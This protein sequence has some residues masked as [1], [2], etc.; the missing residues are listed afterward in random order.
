M[1]CAAASGSGVA[2]RALGVHVD[3]AHLHRAERVG[4]V[5]LAAVALVAEPR[6]LGAP[7][8]LVGLPHVLASEAEPERLEAHRLE[9]DV[10]GEDDEVGPRDLAA[11]LLLHRP[12]QAARLVEAR[13]VG[14][15][16]ERREALHALAATAAAVGD[17]VGAGRVP[18]HADEQRSVVCRSR[19]A[20]SP[21]TSSSPASMSAR[22]VVEVELRE[23]RRV[24]EVD[25]ERT[26][27]AARCGAAPS[28]PAG[29]ATSRGSNAGGGPSA[30][31]HRW[32]GSRSRTRCPPSLAVVWWMNQSRDEA[33]RR[34]A[35]GAA[36]PV[37]D[38][39]LV[40]LVAR[41]VGRGEARNLADRT[42]DVDG[43][44]AGAADEVVVVVADA[45]LV[46]S[47]RA[48]GLDAPDRRPPR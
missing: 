24:V 3:E 33:V 11:V 19:R 22:S 41:V 28:G 34:D 8:D 14:P 13:V 40:D 23:L 47:R 48:R 39:G 26:R 4:E 12:E 17:A 25:A 1:S 15:A 27:A 16:V 32:R 7:E 29:R 10:A 46:A 18:G 6:V 38:L 21:A 35:V 45:V 5:A 43:P 2:V 36:A 9:R 42:V 20:T 30:R 31:G 37:D 44:A